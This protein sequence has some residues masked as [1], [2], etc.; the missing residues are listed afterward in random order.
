M[1]SLKNRKA[2]YEQQCFVQELEQ[3]HAHKAKSKTRTADSGLDTYFKEISKWPLLS[4]DQEQLLAKAVQR[5]CPV[6]R[7]QLISSNLRLVV[8]FARR[9]THLGVPVED[10][11]SAG[12]LGLIRGVE[13]FDQTKGCRFSTYGGL[14]VLQSMK[15]YV[16]SQA[17]RVP[18]PLYMSKLLSRWKRIAVELSIQLGRE[19]TSLEVARRIG[20]PKR[21][22]SSIEA[23]H[24]A[25]KLPSNEGAE[26][27]DGCL[28]LTQIQDCVSAPD[29][30]L[31]SIDSFRQVM[32]AL[33]RLPELERRVLELKF[34]V[35]ETVEH[36]MKEISKILSIS[37]PKIRELEQRGLELMSGLLSA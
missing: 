24:V 6:A 11:I 27:D 5:G 15:K 30:R 7:E 20:I 22:I 18:V 34:G 23:A 31:E 32:N 21:K 14:W 3:E 28:P 16:D 33:E 17:P 36:T 25:Y 4:A 1:A 12:N 8:A 9:Y 2:R 26:G 29:Q 10:I 37:P 35:G 13:S 19:P